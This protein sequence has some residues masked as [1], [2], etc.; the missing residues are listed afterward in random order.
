MLGY[1]I[2]D[3]YCSKLKLVIEIDWSVHDLRKE[4]DD[5]RSIEL[6]KLWLRVIRY[7][8]DEVLGDINFIFE[9][10]KEKLGLWIKNNSIF[11]VKKF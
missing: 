4:Y 7:S 8:N 9:D 11:I 3:F 6:N 2:A 10:L 1:F 5:E